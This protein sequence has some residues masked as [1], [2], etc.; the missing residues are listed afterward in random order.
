MVH[1]R[2]FRTDPA[3]TP[4]RSLQDLIKDALSLKDANGVSAWESVARR[5]MS[6]P[7]NTDLQVLLNRVADLSDAVFGEMCYVDSRGLQALLELKTAKARLSTLTSA[8]VYSLK[9]QGA[10]A[11]TQ[12]IRGMAYFLVV[13]NHLFFVRT[14]ALTPLNIHA[15]LEWLIRLGPHLG[16]AGQSVL[17]ESQLD[18]SVVGDKLGDVRALRVGGPTFPQMRLTPTDSES[19]REQA[20]TRKVAEKFV[21]FERALGIVKALLG[22]VQAKSLVDSLGPKERLVVDAEVKVRGTRTAASKDKLREIA[23]GLDSVTEGEV[24]VETADG[25]IRDEDVILRV[26]MPFDVPD[27]G[28]MLLDFDN[29]ADQLQKVYHRFAEDGKIKA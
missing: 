16:K 15:F 11:G 5:I 26:R 7:E 24:R 17:F 21:E 2:E 4:G 6:L 9:E 29:V 1:Y 14:H 12:Y 22:E 3:S 20:V 28:T 13:G 23:S 27:K 18:R 19:K 25:T 10:P 8:E